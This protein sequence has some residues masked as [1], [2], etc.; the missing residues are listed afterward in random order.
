MLTYLLPCFRKDEKDWSVLKILEKP[1]FLGSNHTI[2]LLFVK[3]WV[4]RV[5]MRNCF[6]RSAL[7][8]WDHQWIFLP[9]PHWWWDVIVNVVDVQSQWW[10][11]KRKVSNL[12]YKRSYINIIQD[13][14]P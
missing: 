3:E 8:Q 7:R 2:E 1:H 13:M 12:L 4:G 5:L 6:V 14:A 9:N 10:I 11:K